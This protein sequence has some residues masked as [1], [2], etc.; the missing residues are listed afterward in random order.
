MNTYLIEEMTWPEIRDAMAGG[1]D[2]I[3]IYAAS[4]EQHGPHL[5]ERTDT[6]FGYQGGIDLAK[7]LGNALVAPVIRPGLSKHHVCLPGSLTLRPEVFRGVLEDYV[8]CYVTH[9]FKKI[10]LTSSHGGN[11]GAVAD[12][13]KDLAVKYPDTCIVSG[14]PL[15]DLT[16]ALEEV[17]R[18]EGMP[19]GV[20]G[21]HACDWETS[22][23]LHF[24][25]QHV[26][27][28]KAEPGFVGTPSPEV[29]DRFFTEGV[30]A[31]SEIGVMGDPSHADA[32]R[33]ERYFN[34]LQDIQERVVR[35]NIEAWY[36]EHERQ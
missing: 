29:L 33:G 8:A 13:A 6:E 25:P 26:R 15:S 20:C 36:A 12:I 24:A 2:T 4:I 19:A 7:R 18:T 34:Y 1:V 31:V 23:M 30:T 16:V 9:G 21:G 3:I 35:A 22:V 32:E 17:E 5:A 10:V 28:D 11:F 14:M 27:M